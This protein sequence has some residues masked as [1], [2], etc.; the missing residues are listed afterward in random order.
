MIEALWVKASIQLNTK[1][2]ISDIMIVACNALQ[3]VLSVSRKCDLTNC[4]IISDQMKHY[5]VGPVRHSHN[6]SV[7]KKPEEQV[8][9]NQEPTNTSR[10]NYIISTSLSSAISNLSNVQITTRRTL[11]GFNREAQPYLTKLTEHNYLD[12]FVGQILKF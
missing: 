1:R 9:A 10:V 7:S 5:T 4:I 11:C 8:F 12:Y 2:Q 6:R 3:S